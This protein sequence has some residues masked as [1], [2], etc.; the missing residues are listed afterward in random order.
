MVL[1]YLISEYFGYSTR[2]DKKFYT[3]NNNFEQLVILVFDFYA[4]WKRVAWSN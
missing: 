3:G 4:K 2:M 1:T